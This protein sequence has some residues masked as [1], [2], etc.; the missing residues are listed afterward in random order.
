MTRILFFSDLHVEHDRQGS[1]FVPPGPADFDRAPDLVL[2]GGDTH[3][4]PHHLDVL[5]AIEDALDCPVV[6]VTGN[7]EPYGWDYDRFRSDEALRLDRLR[8]SGRRIH[9]LYGNSVE[10]CGLRVAGAPLWT[11]MAFNL[12]RF[13]LARIRAGQVMADYRMI[14]RRGGPDGR[15]TTADT[16]ALHQADKA[17]LIDELGRRFDGPTLVLTHHMPIVE[18]ID[19]AFRNDAINCAFA[20][21]LLAEIAELDFDAWIFG[22]SHSGRDMDI[23]GPHGRRRFLSNPRGY[24]GETARFD[25]LR[26][27]DI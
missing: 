6:A 25:R 17:A 20:S 4:A 5:C 27:L 24:P 1:V 11:D 10:I 13:P 14:S 8:Q 2:V 16:V 7:H 9:V 18:A 23:D 12:G 19:P 26:I 3:V 15:F 22:H 21:D